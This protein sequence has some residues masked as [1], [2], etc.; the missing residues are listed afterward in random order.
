MSLDQFTLSSQEAIAE[1]GQIAAKRNHQPA[2][3]IVPD[4]ASVKADVA[5]GREGLV[6][7]TAEREAA[8]R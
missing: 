7:T 8:R 1:S 2:E 5:R 3:G 4:G 6:L